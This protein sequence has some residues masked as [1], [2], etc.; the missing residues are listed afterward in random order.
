MCCI[1]THCTVIDFSMNGLCTENHSLSQRTPKPH[2]IKVNWLIWWCELSYLEKFN[3]TTLR[4]SEKIDHLFS[5]VTI[6]RN[7]FPE[8]RG[9]DAMPVAS[10]IQFIPI[11]NYCWEGW[12]NCSRFWPAQQRN[13]DSEETHYQIEYKKHAKINVEFSRKYESS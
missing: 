11:S 6:F 9:F 3:S 12:R 1:C 10:G 5:L 7:M 2:K 13:R 8:S 4:F